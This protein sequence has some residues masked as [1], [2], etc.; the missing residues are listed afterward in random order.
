M[1]GVWTALVTPFDHS[2]ALDLNTWDQLLERQCAAGVKGVVVCGTTGEAPTLSVSEKLSLIKRTHAT[3]NGR[4]RVMAGTGGSCTSSSIELSKLSVQAGA[5]S[6][7]IVTPPYNKPPLAGLKAHYKALCEATP[8]TPMV[9]YH[10]PGRTGQSLSPA[11]MAELLAVHDNL[12]AVKEASGDPELLLKYIQKTHE[13]APH[14]KITWL[15]GNDG[16]FLPELSVGCEGAISVLSNIFPGYV[17]KLYESFGRGEMP[18]AG[19]LHSTLY[20]LTEALFWQ[21]NPLPIKA[22]LG[23]LSLIPG[24]NPFR[25]PLVAPTESFIDELEKVYSR[26]LTQLESLS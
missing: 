12:V 17:Q 24:P 26:T 2:G 1:N 3:S 20:P 9:L 4:V 19:Q 5:D 11:D 18:R 13:Q 22:L 16:T 25:L 6:L 15:S 21:S 23:R 8:C 14:K 10:V 7:L